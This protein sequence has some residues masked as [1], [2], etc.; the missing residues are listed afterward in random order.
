[1]GRTRLSA[2][3]WAELRQTKTASCEA[4]RFYP[5]KVNEIIDASE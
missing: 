4:I 5:V 3:V 2:L 1:M